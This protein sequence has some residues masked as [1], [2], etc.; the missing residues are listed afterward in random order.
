[1]FIKY[2]SN[3]EVTYIHYDPFNKQYGLG[4]TQEELLL[5]GALVDSIPTPQCPNNKVISYKYNKE[6]NI[7]YYELVD[8]ELTEEEKTQNKI[9][10]LEGEQKKQHEGILSNMVA[11]TEIYE[12]LLTMSV[13][14]NIDARFQNLGG[15]SMVEVYVT[16]ILNGVK[17]IDQVPTIIREKVR[18]QLDLLVK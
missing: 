10:V 14:K 11:T 16:L 18:E 15:D 8:R 2:N 7:V 3:F 1:M 9:S 17:T 12:M 4:K 6:T 5:E 13:S